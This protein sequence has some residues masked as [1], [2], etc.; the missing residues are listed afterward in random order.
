MKE[1]PLKATAR[2]KLIKKDADGN[3]IEVVENIV[4]LTEEEAEALWHSQQQGCDS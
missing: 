1:I 2:V 4:E 3:I